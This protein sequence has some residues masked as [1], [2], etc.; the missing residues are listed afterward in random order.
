M[1]SPPIQG[2]RQH[3]S[4]RNAK[5]LGHPIAI[6]AVF[7]S[8]SGLVRAENLVHGS[9]QHGCSSGRPA[10]MISDHVPA[11]RVRQ[12]AL[13]FRMEVRDRPSPQGRSQWPLTE[14]QD[15]KAEKTSV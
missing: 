15:S 9:D 14:H 2:A 12:E 6:C 11:V 4:W 5:R 8:A 3:Q 1:P 7:E 10:V 13:V